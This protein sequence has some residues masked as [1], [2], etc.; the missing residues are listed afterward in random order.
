MQSKLL[1]QEMSTEE[2]HEKRKFVFSVIRKTGNAE[3]FFLETTIIALYELAE[4]VLVKIEKLQ[5]S[6]LKTRLSAMLNVFMFHVN[7]QRDTRH[8]STA[9][10]KYLINVAQQCIED[11]GFSEINS[12][13]KE[14]VMLFIQLDKFM[15]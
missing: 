9:S 1:W 12:D 13:L 5:E 8:M 10:F 11:G 6:D 2:R 15:E 7:E 4:A 14:L 3:A